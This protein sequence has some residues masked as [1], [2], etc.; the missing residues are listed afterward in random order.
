MATK[1]LF[2]TLVYQSKLFPKRNEWEKVRKSLLLEI[3]DISGLDVAGRDWSK[4]NY[5]GGF[6]SYAS[7]N[8]LHRYSPGFHSLERMLDKHVAKFSKELDWE[9]GGSKLKMTNCW[10]N[11]MGEG[12]QHTMHIHP[13][14]A[15]S[16]TV[17]I[18][19]PKN[20]P[21]LKFE[22]PRLVQFMNCPPRKERAKEENKNFFWAQPEE[23]D[24][25]LF[26][27]WTRHEVPQHSGKRPRISVS[28]NYAWTE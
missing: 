7:A 11:I 6:T 9:L 22:D 19:L 4:E 5:R 8:Q 20:S 16:G 21:G 14:S 25:I 18:N 2:P 17:Y 1:K 15:V 13:L 3:E 24:C 12:T 23:G 10:V 28:F 27:S 26:E